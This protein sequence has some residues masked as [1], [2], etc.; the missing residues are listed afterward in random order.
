MG[1]AAHYSGGL[2]IKELDTHSKQKKG[3]V[4]RLIGLVVGAPEGGASGDG[5]ARC[6][7]D[8]EGLYGTVNEDIDSDLDEEE[9]E[10]IEKLE[11]NK[12]RISIYA[13]NLSKQLGVSDDVAEAGEG[14]DDAVLV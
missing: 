6:D 11:E 5:G 8:A 2:A 4:E 1:S 14:D 12:R 10:E 9:E 7:V 13:S 3:G